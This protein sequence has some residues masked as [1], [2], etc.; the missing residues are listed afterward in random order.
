MK[1]GHWGEFPAVLA[2]ARKKVN[3]FGLAPRGVS[4]RQGNPAQDHPASMF[5]IPSSSARLT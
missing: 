4:S 2:S 5:A 3:R 1:F